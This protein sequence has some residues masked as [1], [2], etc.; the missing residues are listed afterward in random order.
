MAA[1]TVWSGRPVLGLFFVSGACGLVYEVV[2]VRL[3]FW[4]FGNTV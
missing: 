3:L 4:V 1:M 2:W